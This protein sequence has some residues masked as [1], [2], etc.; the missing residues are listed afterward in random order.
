MRTA[1]ILCVLALTALG[2]VASEADTPPPPCAATDANLPA[3]FQ[4]WVSKT[5][6]ES[7][8]DSADLDAHAAPEGKALNTGL[9]LAETV[10]WAAPPEKPLAPMSS[11]FGGLL[12][13]R[14]ALEGTYVVAVSS[15]A[16]L[17]VLKDGRPVPSSAHAH[18]PICS[19][20]HKQVEFHLTPGRYVLQISG[21]PEAHITIL[22]V[23]KP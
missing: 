7:A 10:T 13:L 19:T 16:W 14:P 4:T 18:G 23:R 20:I 1:A 2:A 5:N 17:D 3:P 11:T 8:V 22:F 6:A 15:G 9:H 12:Q 21:A